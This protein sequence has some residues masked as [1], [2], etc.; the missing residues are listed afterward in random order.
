MVIDS[1]RAEAFMVRVRVVQA[2]SRLNWYV[3]STTLRMTGNLRERPRHIGFE[4]GSVPRH[5][6]H[7]VR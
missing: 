2:Y 1:R 3:W 4:P 5:L 7:V 6:C